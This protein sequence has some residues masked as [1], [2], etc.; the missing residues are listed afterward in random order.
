MVHRLL[1]FALAAA[2]LH[3]C[4]MSSE[5]STPA[6]P[7]ELA[8]TRLTDL[9]AAKGNVVS[10]DILD[11][12]RLVA[13]IDDKIYSVPIS[14]GTPS[15][16][17]S[18]ARYESVVV[19]GGGEIYALT[20][21][22]L[23]VIDHI[24][25]TP[26]AVDV[27]IRTAQTEKV[28][29][30]VSPTGE[31][32]L[33]V[34]TY[35]A[36]MTLYT[37]ADRGTTWTTIPLP[38]GFLYGG[39][40]AFGPS[41]E[42]YL[43]SPQGFYSSPD[44]G[45]TWTSY[46]AP[47]ANYGGEL[48][49]RSNGHIL[50]YVPGGGGL[51]LSTDGGASFTDLSQFNNPPY[52]S[53]IVEG[54]DGILYALVNRGATTLTDRPMT[55]AK[56]TDGG[57]TWQHIYFAQGYDFAMKGSVIAVAQ[58]ET[59]SGGVAISTDNGRSFV[60]AGIGSVESIQSFGFDAEGNLLILADR[61]LFRKTSSGWKTLGGQSGF[62]TMATTPQ[63][64]IFLSQ[65]SSTFLSVD[66]GTSWKEAPMPDYLYS[67]IGTIGLPAV[68][69]ARSGD[70]IVSI[71]TYRDDLATH[72]NGMLVRVRPDGTAIRLTNGINYVSI[73]E[74]ATGLLYGQTVNFRTY[75][76][77]TDGGTTWTEVQTAAPGFVFDSRNRFIAYGELGAFRQGSSG[78]DGTKPLTL[79]GFTSQS[80]YVMSARFD[81]HDRLHLLTRDQGLF[82]AT[83]PLP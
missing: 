1:L 50:Y 58:G 2:F 53:K 73:V 67:G 70:L 32:Y 77:S 20:R 72:T 21:D 9:P 82:V 17:H 59:A 16:M 52:F 10:V 14:G 69:G 78:S 36:R 54:A 7:G 33:R 64:T 79:T 76:R 40:L 48:V 56:S 28:T 45:A 39:G 34:Y 74:D 5:P 3:G 42:M 51:R 60:P 46:P 57:M 63:G 12:S 55:V 15:L 22:A 8:M 19:G 27:Q 71:T 41:G 61:T 24:G 37:S 25:G 35:P 23:F 4:G 83:Q 44:R 75:Q 38:S 30:S 29:L 43:S 66:G 65:V 47:L 26:K 31:P 80:N 49:R 62:S 81:S 18:N 13:V 11:A 68:L 6:A